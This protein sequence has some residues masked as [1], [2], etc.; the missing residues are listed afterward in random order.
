M[1]K[2]TFEFVRPG[3]IDIIEDGV[4]VRT[5]R[6]KLQEDIAHLQ[7]NGQAY[8]DKAYHQHTLTM[9]E[10]ALRFLDEESK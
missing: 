2:Y 8:T 9:L 1:S 10:E 7:E 6:V 5:N 3:V 4:Y